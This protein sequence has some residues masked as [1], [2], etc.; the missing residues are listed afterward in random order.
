MKRWKK[1][2]EKSFKQYEFHGSHFFPYDNEEKD[3]LRILRREIFVSEGRNV[4]VKT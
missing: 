2:T 3:V 4:P 1:V